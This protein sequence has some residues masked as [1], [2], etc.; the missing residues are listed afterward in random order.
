MGNK[1]ILYIASSLDGFIARKNGS[2][3]WLDKYN[4]TGNDYG[5]NK[6]L[7]SVDTI[8]VGN[9]TQQQFP[10]KYNGKPCL[11]F[12]RSIQGKDDNLTYVSGN[13]IEVLEKYKP[14]GKIWLVGGANLLG[15]F[16]QNNLIDEFIITVIPELLEDGIPLFSDSDYLKKQKLTFSKNYGNVVQMYYKNNWFK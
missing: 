8:I 5:Y 7:E 11:V 15:Q 2:V 10:Q 4:N 14:L 9:N 16:I 13:I 3:E 1:I 12:S 6:F